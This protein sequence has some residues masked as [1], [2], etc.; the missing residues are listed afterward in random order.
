MCPPDCASPKAIPYSEQ[1]HCDARGIGSRKAQ[2][3]RTEQCH[4]SDDRRDLLLFGHGCDGQGAGPECRRAAGALG[5]LCGTD[6]LGFPVGAAPAENGGADQISGASVSAVDPVDGRNSVLFY[7]SQP[8]PTVG[9]RRA[10][11]DQSC[12]HHPWGGDFSGRKAR[13]TP[14][15]RDRGGDDR[16]ADH[17][18]A[19]QRCV[20]PGRP[21]PAGCRCLL[22]GLC[23]ADPTRRCGRGCVD[24]SFLYRVCRHRALEPSR[25][26]PMAAAQ[27]DGYRVDGYRG[28]RRNDRS[29]CADPGLHQGRGGDAGALFLYRVRPPGPPRPTPRWESRRRSNPP[30]SAAPAAPTRSAPD[31]G[32]RRPR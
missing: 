18:S 22:F 15:C 23:A 26:V 5:A 10:D 12:P 6:A 19:R 20:Q 13:D 17:H 25:A 32:S 3:D 11:V 27:W 24:I 28:H 7:R 9:C 2:H 4:P 21:V 30:R 14:N 16:R 8:D 1:A 31:R 29:A